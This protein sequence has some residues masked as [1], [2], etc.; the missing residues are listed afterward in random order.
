MKLS[1]ILE[2]FT[3]LAVVLRFFCLRFNKTDRFTTVCKEIQPANYLHQ[4]SR[5]SPQ[6]DNPK[7]AGERD[8]T[9]FSK[10]QK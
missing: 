7:D 3:S 9:L 2:I 10:F 4:S 1:L 8:V 6:G 5:P